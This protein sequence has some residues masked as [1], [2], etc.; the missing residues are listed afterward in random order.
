VSVGSATG[1]DATNCPGLGGAKD[2]SAIP[3]AMI[4]VNI[5]R[6]KLDITFPLYFFAY[7]QRSIEGNR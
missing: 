4:L 7:L 1:G 2:K 3:R 5:D 6:D